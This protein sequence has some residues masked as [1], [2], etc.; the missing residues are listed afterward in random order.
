MSGELPE[1]WATAKLTDLGQWGSGGTPLRTRPEFFTD[2]TIPWLKIGD[3][4]DG[5]V[6]SSDE[7]IT[8]VGLEGSTAKLLPP[9][10]LLIAMYGSIGKLGI[11]GIECATNQAIAFCRPYIGTRYLFWTLRNSRESL[12]ALGKGGTQ[13]NI[14]Q[15]VLRDFEVPVAP[16]VEQ[17]RIVAQVEVLLEQVNRAKARLERVPIIL[18]RF[19]QSVLTAACS[20]VLTREWRDQQSTKSETGDALVRRIRDNRPKR[21]GSDDELES[22]PAPSVWDTPETWTWAPLDSL[23]SYTRRAAY[24]VLQPGTDHA[25]GVR[26]VRVCDIHDGNVITGG[27]KRIAP[28]IAAAYPRTCLEGREVL[29]TLVGSI[30]RVAVVPSELAGAN[31]A[32]AVG[33]LPLHSAIEPEYVSLALQHPA[34]GQELEGSAREVARKTL[35]LGLLKAVEIPVPPADEQVEIVRVVHNLFTIADTIE[36]RVTAATTRA[37]KLP[38]AILAK[39]FSGDLVSTEAELARAEG[40]DYETAEALLAKIAATPV[41]AA[42]DTGVKRGRR[43]R[44]PRE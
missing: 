17:R 6:M 36:R 43:T 9:D 27:V 19:R 31:V 22:I 44:T 30:G 38:Q 32:R 25:D 35:N 42:S 39:A 2:G 4:T 26:F 37:D 21:R 3:L 13:A 12:I 40:R 33:V 11:T 10:T 16:L 5:I 41:R 18:K 8:E 20:G 28:S 29:V 23:L 1:G 15:G 14:S 34:K 7:K 24:G